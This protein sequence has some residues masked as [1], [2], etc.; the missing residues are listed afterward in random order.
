M[1][2]KNSANGQPLVEFLVFALSKFCINVY[3]KYSYIIE[4][5]STP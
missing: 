5:I 2:T 3:L 1:N 4:V